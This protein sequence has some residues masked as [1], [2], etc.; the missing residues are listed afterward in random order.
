MALNP[1]PFPKRRRRYILAVKPCPKMRHTSST[2]FRG[3]S[4][5][6]CRHPC[7]LREDLELASRRITS[8]V[9]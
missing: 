1:S 9:D 2:Y 5:S 3:G 6:H 4:A 8:V 7:K